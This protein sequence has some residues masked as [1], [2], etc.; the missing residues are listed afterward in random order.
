MNPYIKTFRTHTGEIVKGAKLR[1]ALNRTAKFYRDNAQAIYDTDPY[2]S[3]VTQETKDEALAKGLAS[4][5]EI[6]KGRVDN[7]TVAQRLDYELTG[8]CIPLMGGV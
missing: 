8:E 2:A 7:L 3:H 5:D 4:A 1:R 6:K